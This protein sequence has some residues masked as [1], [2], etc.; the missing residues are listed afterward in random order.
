MGL[1]IVLGLATWLVMR[2]RQINTA[3]S[4]DEESP[5]GHKGHD[6]YGGPRGLHASGSACLCRAITL[7]LPACCEPDAHTAAVLLP[8]HS[9]HIAPAS[10]GS[11]GVAETHS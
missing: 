3:G 8:W 7:R 1:S 10:A 6:G 2:K 9:P 5:Y 4:S 11:L